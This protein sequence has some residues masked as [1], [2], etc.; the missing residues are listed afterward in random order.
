MEDSA[1]IAKEK[2]YKEQQ[3]GY[4]FKKITNEFPEEDMRK[5]MKEVVKDEIWTIDN[6]LSADTC[7]GLIDC[8]AKEIGYKEA[9][10]A[11]KFKGTGICR[12]L[13]NS[14]F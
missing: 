8:S 13:A 4:L 5:N 6:F 11:I 7:Q 12:L 14:E 10:L 1:K 3:L 2:E 9:D